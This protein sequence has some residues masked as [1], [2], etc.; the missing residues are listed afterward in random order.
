MIK[1]CVRACRGQRIIAMLYEREL[2]LI[3]SINWVL[4]YVLVVGFVH[5][6]FVISFS[7]WVGLLKFLVEHVFSILFYS[8]V[9]L[10]LFFINVLHV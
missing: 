10:K 3:R 6:N 8:C 2:S 4:D 7:S 5:K 1:N 9:N